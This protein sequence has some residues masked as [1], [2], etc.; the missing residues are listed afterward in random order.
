[1]I[2]YQCALTD[3]DYIDFNLYTLR[4]NPA[5]KRALLLCR[6]MAPAMLLLLLVVNIINRYDGIGIL[7]AMYGV[8][9][10]I[11]AFAVK[12]LY[13]FICVRNIKSQLKRSQSL[14]TPEYTLYFNEDHILDISPQQE[15]KVFYEK[16]E[17]VSVHRGSVYIY[18]TSVSAMILPAAVFS[19]EEDRERLLSFLTQRRSDLQIERSKS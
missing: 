17:R 14:Y 19:T 15:T 6:F 7:A 8:A 1:M 11:W 12:P 3:D 16:I 18:P 4:K 9:A 5:Y 13:D 10:V 2:Q